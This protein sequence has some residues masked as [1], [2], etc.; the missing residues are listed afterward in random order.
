MDLHAGFMNSIAAPDHQLRAYVFVLRAQPAAER[1]LSRWSGQLHWIWNQALAEQKARHARGEKY[2]SYVDMAK[3]LTEWRHAPGSIWLAEGPSQ[4]QQHVLKR[5]DEA[6]QRFFKKTG[7]FPRFKKHDDDAGIRFPA[8]NQFVLDQVNGRIKLPKIGWLRLRQSRAVKGEIRNVTVTREG[9]RWLVSIQTR[10][11]A[12]LLAAGLMPTLGIDLGVTAFAATSEGQII[13]PLNA[14]KKQAQR[15]GRYQRSVARKVKG[16]CNRKKAVKRLGALHRRIARQ[17]NDWLHQLTSR[18]ANEHPVITI[19]DLRIMNMTASARG[20]AAK[21][22]KR[23]KQKFGLNK[24][25]LDQGWGEFTRQLGYKLAA[26]GGELI[27]VNPAYSSRTCRMCDHES[28][29]N[30]KTQALF[31]CAACRH[32]EHADLHAAK[33]ILQ[34]GVAVVESKIQA[35]GHAATACGG[36]IRRKSVRKRGAGVSPLKQ[37]P[38]EARKLAQ[39]TER[40]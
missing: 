11:P 37:E 38:T 27:A 13:E 34:R 14:L 6:Y 21:P 3:W 4:P 12:R 17:R 20:T 19:E 35:A 2:A 10:T 18:L 23:V 39:E 26:V 30:R 33:V 24:S 31:A 36:E 25:I 22:G 29:D 15:L 16:S 9:S 5:L 7:G 1:M 8:A 40:A 32:T 28:A